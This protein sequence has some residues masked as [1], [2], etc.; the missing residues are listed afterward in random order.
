[1]VRLWITHHTCA[2]ED[3]KSTEREYW[4]N[5]QPDTR[6]EVVS[7]VEPLPHIVNTIE[8][9]GGGDQVPERPMHRGET[10]KDRILI[11]RMTDRVT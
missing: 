1:M 4:V 6:Q 7:R 10:N 2:E 9:K 11:T 8:E 5:G 3:Y